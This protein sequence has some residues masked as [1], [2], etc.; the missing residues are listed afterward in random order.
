MQYLQR[1]HV[2]ARDTGKWRVR[3][4]GHLRAAR[5]GGLAAPPPAHSRSRCPH[6]CPAP[7][8]ATRAS[9]AFLSPALPHTFRHDLCPCIC[10]ETQ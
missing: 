2:Q 6:L 10:S 4:G 5:K 1:R 9:P 8:S 7:P 3:A